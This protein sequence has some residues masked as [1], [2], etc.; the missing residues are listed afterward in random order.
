MGKGP[1]LCWDNSPLLRGADCCARPI[2]QKAGYFVKRRWETCTTSIAG[3]DKFYRFSSSS[4]SLT[5]HGSLA[6]PALR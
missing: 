1:G 2:I 4:A 6:G 3:P 5:G